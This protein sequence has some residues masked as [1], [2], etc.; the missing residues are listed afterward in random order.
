MNP[1]LL[2]WSTVILG[3]LGAA[4]LGG[5]KPVPDQNDQFFQNALAFVKQVYPQVKEWTVEEAGEQIVSGMNFIIILTDGK[6]MKASVKV[7]V[8]FGGAIK[9]T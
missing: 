8:S 9:I 4:Y 3:V 2:V 1:R 5:Y 6:G 7:F